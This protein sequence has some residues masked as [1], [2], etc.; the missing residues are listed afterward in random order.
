MF[1]SFK[2]TEVGGDM[3]DAKGA[4]AYFDVSKYAPLASMHCCQ[5]VRN[6]H[7]PPSISFLDSPFLK[8]DNHSHHCLQ[9]LFLSQEMSLLGA[10][11]I[12]Q[13]LSLPLHCPAPHEKTVHRHSFSL[14]DI[15]SV[16]VCC[17]KL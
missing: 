8:Q 4:K 5:R 9:E 15:L 17:K 11:F 3:V 16:K 10:S 12:F 2:I 13:S 7:M 6:F 1:A 14:I